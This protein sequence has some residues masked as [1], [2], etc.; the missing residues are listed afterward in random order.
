MIWWGRVSY[1]ADLD[2]GIQHVWHI[3]PRKIAIHIMSF[4]HITSP[5]KGCIGIYT[6]SYRFLMWLIKF[7][8]RFKFIKKYLI[9]LLIWLDFDHIWPTFDHIYSFL[10]GI[11]IWGQK[12][13]F[14][15]PRRKKSGNSNFIVTSKILCFQIWICFNLNPRLN[16]KNICSKLTKSIPK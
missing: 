11:R 15:S 3:I 1:F 10:Q 8:L 12:T 14:C 5:I 2:E 16:F 7:N 4:R 13:Q 6:L 9:C